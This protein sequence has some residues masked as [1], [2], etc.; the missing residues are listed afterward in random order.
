MSENG[1]AMT[2]KVE[3]L[4]N[5]G[6]GLINQPLCGNEAVWGD[7]CVS[8]WDIYGVKQ[9]NLLAFFMDSICSIIKGNYFEIMNWYIFYYI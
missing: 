4:G 6:L 9:E 5:S 1:S 8:Q 3:S 2:L 7:R